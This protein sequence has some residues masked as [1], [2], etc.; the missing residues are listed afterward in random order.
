MTDQE[1]NWSVMT[2]PEQNAAFEL[3]YAEGFNSEPPSKSHNVIYMLGYEAGKAQL[4]A[5]VRAA[6]SAAYYLEEQ[7]QEREVD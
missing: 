2:S 3:G 5:M 4:D 1:Q 7:E 6:N